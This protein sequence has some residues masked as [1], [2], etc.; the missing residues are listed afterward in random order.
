MSCGMLEYFLR[1]KTK[2][3]SDNLEVKQGYFLR[4]IE[5]RKKRNND[6][7]VIVEGEGGTGKSYFALRLAEQLDPRFVDNIDEAIEYQVCFKASEY[8]RAVTVL[9]PHSVLIY[10]EPGQSIHHR[11]FMSDANIILS[12]TMIGYR[13]KR[14][15]SFFCIPIVDLIDKDSQKLTQYMVNI[16]GQGHAEIY[17]TMKQKFGGPPWYKMVVDHMKISLPDCKLTHAYEK[18]KAEIENILYDQ[19]HKKLKDKERIPLSK[20]EILEKIRTDPK[21]F[22]INDVL[23]VPS[24][25][26]EFDIGRDK[27]QAIKAKYDKSLLKQLSA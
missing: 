20:D 19:Y 27:A 10:D 2:P 16:T 3:P 6:T 12:K 14:F 22:M 11:E 17:K 5:A 13:F 15:V 8:M 1:M 4:L 21:P 26:A 25:C 7:R 18:K 24:I 23:H 9:P